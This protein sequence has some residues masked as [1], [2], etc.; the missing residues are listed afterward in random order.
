MTV[1]QPQHRQG[2]VRDSPEAEQPLT[3]AGCH[4]RPYACPLPV[5]I[6]KYRQVKN[7]TN[8]IKYTTWKF[9]FFALIMNFKSIFLPLL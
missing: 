6:H 4:A 7:L 8:F 2:M 3:Q 9:D 5:L 1:G